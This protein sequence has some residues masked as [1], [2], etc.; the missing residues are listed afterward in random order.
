MATHT[1][2]NIVKNGTVYPAGTPIEDLPDICRDNLDQRQ[3]DGPLDEAKPKKAKR[4][5][6][7]AAAPATASDSAPPVDPDAPPPD[8]D[9]EPF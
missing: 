8:P 6:P 4:N 5:V 2:V 9:D 3:V 7:P 1:T